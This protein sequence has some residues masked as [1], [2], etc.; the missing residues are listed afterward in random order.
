[1]AEQQAAKEEDY[2]GE[3]A[4]IMQEHDEAVQ[5]SQQLIAGKLGR[6]EQ[7]KGK[8]TSDLNT[9]LNGDL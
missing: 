8:L 5:A 2:D 9:K 3:Y 7:L 1:M 4:R 6:N